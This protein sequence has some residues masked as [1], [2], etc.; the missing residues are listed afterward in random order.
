MPPI[1]SSLM[2]LIIWA[3]FGYLLGSIPSGVVLTRV[4]YKPG[5]LHGD[6]RGIL[7]AERVSLGSMSNGRSVASKE[8]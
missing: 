8:P 7:E 4:M 1:E 6:A 3:V 2:L 5:A